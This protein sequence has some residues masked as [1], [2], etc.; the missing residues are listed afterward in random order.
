MSDELTK[1]RLYHIDR[2][3]VLGLMLVIL[4]HVDLP[5]WLAQIRSFDVPLLVF[6]SAY[7]ARKSYKNCNICGYYRKRFFR[8][9]VPAWIFAI[10][11]W[12]VQSVVLTPPTL[13][14]VLKGITFQRDTNMLGML[15]V[16][17]VYI[18]CA[19][20]IPIIG[21]LECYTVSRVDKYPK[22]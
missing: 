5:I 19:L 4:A 3:K 21:R 14:D 11:F 10:V 22:M 17:W 13:V 7:L 15:W 20:L 1:V 6:V 18:V 2:L 9:A 16:I 8:L 12:I